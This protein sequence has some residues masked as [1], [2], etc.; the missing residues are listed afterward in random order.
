MGHSEKT[1]LAV[2]EEGLWIRSRNP[3][4]AVNRI[5]EDSQSDKGNE[6]VLPKTAFAASSARDAL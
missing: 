3:S 2:K 1:R 4:P 6:R 5:H